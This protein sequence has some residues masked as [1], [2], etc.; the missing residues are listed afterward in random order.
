MVVE[1]QGV[2]SSSGGS[3][4]PTPS[5]G[6]MDKAQNC[7]KKTIEKNELSASISALQNPMICQKV[8]F[9]E[10]QKKFNE[11]EELKDSIL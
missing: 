9:D 7:C 5:V 8:L 11:D 6:K 2:S 10:I 4:T 1:Q 3:V